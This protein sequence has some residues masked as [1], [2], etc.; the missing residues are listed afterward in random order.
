MVSWVACEGVSAVAKSVVAATV[1][2][3]RAVVPKADAQAVEVVQS[4][5]GL[6]A[7]AVVLVVMAAARVAWSEYRF[8]HARCCPN[9]QPLHQRH[10]ARTYD[11]RGVMR[12]HC[13]FQ[14]G[15]VAARSRSHQNM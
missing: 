6:A 15:G 2:E 1:V 7:L 8:A 12:P 4:A 14:W 3:V 13:N 11:F 10:V 5:A 9:T